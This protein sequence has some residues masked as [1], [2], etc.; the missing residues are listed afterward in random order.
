MRCLRE[1]VEKAETLY[2]VVLAYGIVFLGKVQGIA[3]SVEDFFG[4]FGGEA[5]DELGVAAGAGRIEDQ[6]IAV[7][8]R[9]IFGIAAMERGLASSFYSVAAGVFNGFG[10]GFYAC[11]LAF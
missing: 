3:G 2:G 9:P 7:E 4:A 6:E 8:V 1:E 10:H 5:F 11:E